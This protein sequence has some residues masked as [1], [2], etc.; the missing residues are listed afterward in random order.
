MNNLY[1]YIVF[2]W[3]GTFP[4]IY[5]QEK[6]LFQV[7]KNGILLCFLYSIIILRTIYELMR[8]VI[9]GNLKKS[10]AVSLMIFSCHFT[11]LLIMI[12]KKIV[13]IEGMIKSYN[14][15]AKLRINDIILPKGFHV[16]FYINVLGII[17]ELIGDSISS[18]KNGTYGAMMA[19]IPIL[20]FCIIGIEV[21]IVILFLILSEL[22]S[23]LN[24]EVQFTLV[25][26]LKQ[27][28]NMRNRN[29][30]MYKICKKFNLHY[31]VDIIITLSSFQIVLLHII[32][33][34]IKSITTE[35][36][37]I[38][39]ED[40]HSFI[41]FVSSMSLIVRHSFLTLYLVE[42]S[43]NLSKKSTMSFYNILKNRNIHFFTQETKEQIYLFLKEL[44]ST[45]V[46]ISANNCYD[47]NRKFV[48]TIAGSITA[49][50]VLV[51]TL[52][53]DRY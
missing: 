44:H 29:L 36:L 42:S 17:L 20:K 4:I 50:L 26:D 13:C 52:I 11:G 22:Y 1:L 5:N 34:T 47:I 40:I 3:F 9:S 53:L 37:F 10:A 27:I 6:C 45:E 43:T 41:K 30:E 35:D 33:E 32:Y 24:K 28:Q 12:T 7:S 39:F 18:I 46:I 31:N 38:Y 49:Y 51:L 8:E 16:T 14:N 15:L 25:N 23:R 19:Y 2:K 48:Y 21:Q